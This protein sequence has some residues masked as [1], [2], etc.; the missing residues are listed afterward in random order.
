VGYY[1][2]P[3]DEEIQNLSVQLSKPQTQLTQIQNQLAKE[4]FQINVSNVKVAEVEIISEELKPVKLSSV[5]F[6]KIFGFLGIEN[7]RKK[8]TTARSCLDIQIA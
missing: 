5:L 7:W 4:N 3:K 2:S 8:K 1:T 6:G